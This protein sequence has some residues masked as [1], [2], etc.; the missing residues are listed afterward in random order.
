MKKFAKFILIFGSVL[1]FGGLLLTIVALACGGSLYSVEERLSRLGI[2]PY[3]PFSSNWRENYNRDYIYYNGEA[4]YPDQPGFSDLWD[5]ADQPDFAIPQDSP[6]SSNHSDPIQLS[7]I[8]D[9]GKYDIKNLD[10]D[11]GLG[12]IRIITGEDFGIIYGNN[13]TRRLYSEKRSG[14]KWVISSNKIRG[15]LLNYRHND[16]S[17]TI[18]I[19]QDFIAEHLR[20]NL[21]AGNMQAN[22]LQ[23]IT[24]DLDIGLGNCSIN[25]LLAHDSWLTVGV[26]H[27]GIAGFAANTSHLEVGLGSMEITLTQPLNQYRYNLE[28]GLGNVQLGNNSYNGVSAVNSGNPD[29]PY[30]LDINCGLG[31]VRIEDRN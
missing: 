23:A 22:S 10:F 2:M 17:L 28:V 4:I 24:V 29:A 5:I 12:D 31:S 18:I 7:E 30:S 16:L 14:D 21:G 11:L 8:Y 1:F 27:L 13:K 19:P 26:G 25:K 15:G 20:I 9:T 3:A 6:D